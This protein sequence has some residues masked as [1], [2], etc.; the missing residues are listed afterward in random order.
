MSVWS[1]HRPTI[2]SKLPRHYFSSSLIVF[3]D[4]IYKLDTFQDSSI[5]GHFIN[6]SFEKKYLLDISLTCHF[7]KTFLINLTVYQMPHHEQTALLSC[8]LIKPVVISSMYHLNKLFARHF[9]NLSFL[10]YILIKLDSFIK[11]HTTS[12][13]AILSNQLPILKE[14]CIAPMVI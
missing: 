13:M 3:P 11:C 10:K 1:F 12:I 7:S 8:Y 6:Q 4:K 14:N 5:N 9:I 2:S